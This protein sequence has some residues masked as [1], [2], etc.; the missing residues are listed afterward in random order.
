MPERGHSKDGRPRLVSAASRFRGPASS[1]AQETAARSTAA[2][3]RY[4]RPLFDRRQLE[5]EGRACPCVGVRLHPNATAVC[6]RESSCNRKAE[7][8][9][10]ARGAS[11]FE[12]VEDSF[13]V[14]LC[15]PG[16]PIADADQNAT[17]VTGDGDVDR[18]AG[19]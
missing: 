13:P 16:T 3:A 9:P 5:D 12:G 8:T 10:G 2:S 15:D 6:L 14:G 11:P 17:A 7:A 4:G 19:R 1:F 18:L